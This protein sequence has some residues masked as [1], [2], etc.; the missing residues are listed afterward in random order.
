M[1]KRKYFKK[2]LIGYIVFV[3]I[4][5]LLISGVFFYKSNQFN[6]FRINNSQK[7]SLQQFKNKVD[8]RLE[9]AVKMINQLRVDPDVI[10]FDL[11]NEINYY[12][13]T[14]IYNKLYKNMNVFYDIGLSIGISKLNDN[15]VI[16]PKTTTTIKQFYD[17]V[18]IKENKAEQI[19]EYF[20]K[21]KRYY[22]NYY[23]CKTDLNLTNKSISKIILV[24]KKSNLYYFIIFNEKD[25]FPD[26]TKT[27]E[28]FIIYSKG[29]LITLDTK[30]NQYLKTNDS[31]IKKLEDISKSIT[32][33]TINIPDNFL[34]SN[35]IVRFITSDV[36][37][38]CLYTYLTPRFLLSKSMINIIEVSIIIYV[39][40]AV[41]GIIL[42]FLVTKNI[43]RPIIEIMNIF[44]GFSQSN[45]PNELNFIQKRAREIKDANE[46]LNQVIKENNLP[47][48]IKFLRELVYGKVSLE[49]IKENIKKYN[50]FYLNSGLTVCIIEL[51]NYHDFYESFS[52][53]AIHKI[54]NSILNLLKKRIESEIECEIFELNYKRY[55]I[56]LK[57]NNK[58]KLKG[59]IRR[60]LTDIDFDYE[61]EMVAALGEPV[62]SLSEVDDSAFV[63][64]F[65]LESRSFLDK[66]LIL[67][68]EEIEEMSDNIYYYP[69]DF[70]RKLI[71]FV[72]KGK[73]DEMLNMLKTVINDNLKGKKMNRE[74]LTEFLFSII[75]TINRILQQLN[76]TATDISEKG[77]LYYYQLMNCEDRDILVEKI[78]KLFVKITDIVIANTM[79]SERTFSDQ[80]VS[81]IHCN[82]DKDI[83]LVDL[84]KEFNYSTGYIGKLFKDH[85]NENFKVYLDKYRIKRAKE[86]LKNGNIKIKEIAEK[87]GCN[88]VNTFIRMF[89][90]Y[91]GIS[92]GKYPE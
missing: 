73:K 6:E 48:K 64:F 43:Y 11:S 41:I 75:G 76:L 12:T 40:L 78:E 27:E 29:S 63:A 9:L 57:G 84:A 62:N 66:R 21:N 44:K 23:L 16:T 77:N 46:I 7:L 28:N 36:L 74:V 53:E 70:E 26:K 55:T 15:L 10:D 5:T 89:K 1:K 45:E 14:Q 35:Y 79:E 22:G 72:I 49:N 50:L 58:Q 17:S 87:V 71:D 32:Q 54:N 8:T 34:L 31:F 2:I 47:L 38:G 25:I 81:F 19:K 33:K 82:Y 88:S 30:I 24:H 69:L 83:S 60:T 37:H 13:V 68:K 52:K 3:V 85:V 91:E 86:L 56:I 4:Y 20:K 65:L 39:I 67:T 80:L 18:G 42:A 51:I 59:I 90:K 92:P 61:I